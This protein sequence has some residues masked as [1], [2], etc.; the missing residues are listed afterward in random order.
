MKIF[1]CPQGVPAVLNAPKFCLRPFGIGKRIGVH[2]TSKVRGDVM[3]RTI[4]GLLVSGALFAQQAQA[5]L[6]NQRIVDLVQTGVSQSEILRLIATA[7][8]FDFDLR[9]A[10]TR[11]HDQSRCLGGG[12]QGHRGAGSRVSADLASAIAIRCGPGLL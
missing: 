5:P 9:P 8:R 4:L 7:Q 12:H 6:A 3:K 1:G 11:D 2:A 10:S